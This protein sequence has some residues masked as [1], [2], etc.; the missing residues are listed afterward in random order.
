MIEALLTTRQVAEAL[1]ISPRSVSDRRFRDRI[2]LQAVKI[3]G[4][5]RFRAVAVQGV[6]R[7]EPGTGRL[8]GVGKKRRAGSG[9]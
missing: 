7:P 3:G 5:V 9:R 2:G 1:K 4:A 8:R 6:V